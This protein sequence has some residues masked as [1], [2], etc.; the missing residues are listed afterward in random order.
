MD[1]GRGNRRGGA[2]GPGPTT[3]GAGLAGLGWNEKRH[4]D[5][6]RGAPRR[7]PPT[8]GASLA[9]LG[10]NE[11]RHGDR[12]RGAPRRRPPTDGAGLA[13]LV[14]MTATTIAIPAERGAARSEWLTL[15]RRLA[16]RRT[17][18]FGLVVVALVFAAALGAPWLS[19]WDPIEQDI[20]NRL[21]PPG[22]PDPSGRV[23]V[24][25]TDHLGRDLLARVIFG[26]RPALLVGV[27]AVAISG[28][29]GMLVG[30]VS[31]YFG[32][33][34]D[35]VLMRLADTQ[36]AFPFLLL[37]VALVRVL[38]PRLP[39]LLAVTGGSSRVAYA[40]VL[41][42]PGLPPRERGVGPAR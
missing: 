3:D 37:G 33:R 10:W 8:D 22:S 26:A 15:F 29:I 1:K 13:A 27:A 20:T 30:L 32:G 36:L 4:G 39:R 21:K 23:H 7:R 19:P 41:R 40:P 12:S 24:L 6:S 34:T 11:K 28:V 31:G 9:A 2:P 35:D 16:R 42:G 38:G 5:G 14:T 25:G 17:A 18:L